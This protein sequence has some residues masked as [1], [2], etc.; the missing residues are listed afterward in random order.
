[1]FSVD[2]ERRAISSVGVL[3]D[4]IWVH[5]RNH[6]IIMLGDNDKP[7]VTI[8]LSHCGFCMASVMGSWLAY[9]DT[10]AGKHF[11]KFWSKN[12]EDRDPVAL[13]DIPIV[14]ISNDDDIFI[15]DEAG[16]L[17][18][19]SDGRNLQRQVRLF[20]EPIFCLASSSSTLACGSSKPPILLLLTEDIL[21]EQ[22]KIH[23]PQASQGVGSMAFST[24]G[25]T[26]IAGFWDGSI[27]AFSVRKNTI[28]LYLDLHTQTISQLLWEEVNGVDLVIAASKDEKLS[29]WKF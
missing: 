5:V 15:G 1:C 20:S 22:R 24:S 6:A 28:L 17:S 10:V 4:F 29:L 21:E 16:T 12:S 8:H 27:R 14:L 2:N 3:G 19:I 25:K 23:Y 13:K 11:L 9:P 7:Q 18:Q 26:L